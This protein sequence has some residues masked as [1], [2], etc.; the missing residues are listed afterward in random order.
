M[1]NIL[2]GCS[3]FYNRHWKGVFYP[4]KLPQS[5]WFQFYA[6]HF[7]TL[8]LNVTFYRFPTEAA[9]HKWYV[10]SPPHFLFAVKVPRAITHFKK[11]KDCERLLS[12][13]YTACA[14]GLKEKLACVLFQFPPSFHY[15]PENLQLIL[16][17][18]DP[19]FKN[20]IEFRHAGWWH[21]QVYDILAA[22]RIIFCSVSHPAMPEHIVINRP[23]AYYRVHG[24]PRMFY[25]GFETHDQMHIYRQLTASNE[26]QEAFIFFNNTAGTAG[27]LN[28]MEMQYLVQLGNE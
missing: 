9:L 2:T 10:Q 6:Q 19:R 18:A 3:G 20:V 25:S 16:S 14:L 8:E 21:Q 17:N 22:H 5:R 12:D 7:H 23:T 1:I 11:L 27:I 4:V 15:T 28:A 13:F 24:R 26:L